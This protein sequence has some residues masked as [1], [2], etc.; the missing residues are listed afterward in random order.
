VARHALEG[1]RRITLAPGAK[2]TVQ[3]TLTPRQ[4]SRLTAQ[5]K[6]VELAE[7]VQV[8]VGGGQPLA[9]AVSAGKVLKAEMALTGSQVVID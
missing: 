4:L 6:R 2:Q 3:F 9:T 1:F 8:F 7:K 5:A